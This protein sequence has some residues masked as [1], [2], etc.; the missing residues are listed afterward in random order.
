MP[1][2]LLQYLR[3]N[4]GLTEAHVAAWKQRVDVDAY[5]VLLKDGTAFDVTGPAIYFFLNTSVD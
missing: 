3:E 5:R 4:Y 1:T 2:D